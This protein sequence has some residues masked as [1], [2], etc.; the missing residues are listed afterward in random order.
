[1]IPS[2]GSLIATAFATLA[3]VADTFRKGHVHV[4]PRAGSWLGEMLG[5]K[6]TMLVRV[7]LANKMARI[8]CSRM[9]QGGVYKARLVALHRSVTHNLLTYEGRHA[10]RGLRGE[11][12]E[13]PRVCSCYA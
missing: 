6:P 13:R 7:A 3:P 5:R 9:A 4:S 11:G 2:I 1:M 10:A 12:R 8:V